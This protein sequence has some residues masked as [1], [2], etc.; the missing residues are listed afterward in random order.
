[1]S[2]PCIDCLTLPLCRSKYSH[3]KPVHCNIIQEYFQEPLTENS[4][5]V[6][7]FNNFL[8]NQQLA[9]NYSKLLSEK[10]N[11]SNPM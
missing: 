1:M 2:L 3:C 4:S 9:D 10:E 6:S 11:V 5:R 8:W 7:E